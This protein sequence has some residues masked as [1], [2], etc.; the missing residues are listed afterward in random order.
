MTNKLI[1]ELPSLEDKLAATRQRLSAMGIER[2]AVL[3]AVDSPCQ[4][5]ADKLGTVEIEAYPDTEAVLA[6]S[7]RRGVASI[8]P[9]M[10]GGE[11]IQQGKQSMQAAIAKRGRV[12]LA[13]IDMSPLGSPTLLAVVAALRT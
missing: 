10:E 8:L 12:A 4:E 3:K 7:E 2:L 9:L 13:A 11:P 6:A 1:R 5:L